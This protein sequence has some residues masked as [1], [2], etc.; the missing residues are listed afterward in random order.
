MEKPIK[1]EEFKEIVLPKRELG[2]TGLMVTPI[3]I[4]TAPLGSMP[5]D[6]GY[7]VPEDSAIATLQRAFM[8]PVNFI[9]TA[10]V[11]GESEKR[12]GMAIRQLGGMPK[13][14]VL[15]T[16]VDRN[17]DTGDFSGEQVKRSLERSLDLLGVDN[18]PLVYL[19]DPEHSS[20]TFDQ[21]MASGGAIDVL[22]DYKNQGVIG[23]IGIAGGPIDL[24]IKYVQT[25]A[26]KAAI[27]HSRYTLLNI[28]AEPLLEEASKGEVALVNAAPFGGGILA[29]STHDKYAYREASWE[30]RERLSKI[31]AVCKRFGVPLK[32]VAFQFSLKDSRITSTIVGVKNADEIDEAVALSAV[33]VPEEIWSEIEPFANAEDPEKD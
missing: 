22:L 2:S 4:G 23:H 11:Y 27:T 14:V 15:A 20:T 32:A 8:S 30:L 3:C 13:D 26:F 29:D 10:S 28:S 24:L 7:S 5:E 12:I 25:G 21:I 9:D 17:L 19:H 18:L 6:F 1:K 16:K 33:P 31:E